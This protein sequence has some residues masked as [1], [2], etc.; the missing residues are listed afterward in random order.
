MILFNGAQRQKKA[1]AENLERLE[2]FGILIS[3][4]EGG[5]TRWQ[6]AQTQTQQAA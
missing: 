6:F 2:W 1:I 3:R 5:V 4:V